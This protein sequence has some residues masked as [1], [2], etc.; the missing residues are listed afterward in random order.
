MSTIVTKKLCYRNMTARC[1]LYK[2]I[3]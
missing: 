1:T 3:E 2:W